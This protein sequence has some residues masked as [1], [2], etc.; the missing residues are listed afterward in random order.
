MTNESEMIGETIERNRVPY[1]LEKRMGKGMQILGKKK[2][3]IQ[4]A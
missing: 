3:G 4:H 1:I 2:L